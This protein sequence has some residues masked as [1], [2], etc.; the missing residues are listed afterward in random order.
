M[1]KLIFVS[2][3]LMLTWIAACGQSLNRDAEF[4]STSHDFGTI[5]ESGGKVSHRFE[6]KNSGK[7]PLVVLYARGG[8]NCVSTEIPRQPVKP[9][10]TAAITVTFDPE[11]RPGHFSK[12]INIVYDGKKFSKL[13]ISGTVQAAKKHSDSRYSNEIG[14]GI[15]TN[16]ETMDFG[17]VKAG[18]HKEMKLK[19][20]NDCAVTV[21]LDFRIDDPAAGVSVDS[22]CILRPDAD[23]SVTVSVCPSKGKDG[24]VTTSLTPIANG[25]ELKPII[26]TYIPL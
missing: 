1:K 13:R 21:N 20:T 22:G 16:H 19:F 8:C 17:K 15:K 6:V 3:L 9:G 11:N 7:E 5:K 14:H 2:A 23:G 12:E 24:K 4:D 10:E 18:T 26:I 25:Y